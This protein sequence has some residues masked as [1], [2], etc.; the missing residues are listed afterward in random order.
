MIV[1]LVLCIWNNVIYNIFICGVFGGLI[2]FFGKVVEVER[3]CEYSGERMY[4]DM[5]CYKF[6][7][8]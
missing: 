3:D 5:E 1:I 7:L 2:L 8:L 6:I 4:V